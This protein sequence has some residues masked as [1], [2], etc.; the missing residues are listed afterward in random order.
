MRQLVFLSILLMLLLFMLAVPAGE[1]RSIKA[2]FNGQEATVEE[3]SLRAGEEFTIDLNITPDGDSIAYI[4]L[5]EPGYMIA[6]DR[7]NGEKK[8]EFITVRCSEA[9]PLRLHWV[10]APN[11]AWVN[12]TAPVNMYCQ[13]NHPGDTS[14]YATSYFT[15]VDAMIL[16]R[17]SVEPTP[18]PAASSMTVISVIAALVV[19]SIGCI[20]D[21]GSEKN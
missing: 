2:Y 8:G 17:E 16:P 9:A 3:T 6:Y 19:T 20:R 4:L 15:I 21:N 7:I 13:L 11:D 1:T 14:P 5:T 18:L 12:G 10:L